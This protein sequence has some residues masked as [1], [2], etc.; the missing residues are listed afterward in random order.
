M[1][2]EGIQ[3]WVALPKEK[4]EIEPSFNHFKPEALP[5]LSLGD[6]PCKLI[7]G[8]FEG[9]ISPVPTHSPMFYLNAKGESGSRFKA[10]L[11]VNQEGA[12]YI[13]RG[14]LKGH[15]GRYASGAM[16][17]FEPGS[18]LDFELTEESHFMFFG[19]QPFPEKRFM[20]WNFV[21]HDPKKIEAA[22]K[23][24]LSG[25][26]E[27]VINEDEMIPLPQERSNR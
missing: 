4:E 6:I 2:L 14:E 18:S 1:A 10:K 19:G 5:E 25:E 22:K 26:Y 17:A 15:E 3:V 24:W 27:P 11:P 7:A 12:I 16:V 20:D 9:Q 13:I 8:E 23:K 21:S